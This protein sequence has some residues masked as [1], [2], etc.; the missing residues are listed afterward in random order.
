MS[1]ENHILF[2]GKEI[3]TMYRV[4]MMC[5]DFKNPTPYVDYAAE[6]KLFPTEVEARAVLLAHALEEVTELN[7]GDGL[8]E[9]RRSFI[10]DLDADDDCI[11]RAWDGDDYIPVTTYNVEEYTLEMAITDLLISAFDN[12][13]EYFNAIDFIAKEFGVSS[14]EVLQ[15]IDKMV[16]LSCDRCID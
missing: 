3:K 7:W 10:P 13:H 6:G 8:S 9:G 2:K 11:I 1:D 15:K 16:D 4:K 14:D 12:D 5:W